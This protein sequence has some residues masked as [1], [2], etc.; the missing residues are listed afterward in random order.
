MWAQPC[1]RLQKDQ[2]CMH[3]VP[4]MG[5]M[6]SQL[7]LFLR[8]SL[9]LETNLGRLAA[10]E[11]ASVLLMSSAESKQGAFEAVVEDE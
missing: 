10:D 11:V 9:S 4:R 8:A 1:V 6:G 5:V 7:P 2:A 3:R